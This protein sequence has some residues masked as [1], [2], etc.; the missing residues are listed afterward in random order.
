MTVEPISNCMQMQ[1]ALLTDTVALGDFR[2]AVSATRAKYAGINVAHEKII[3][4]S[5]SV[6]SLHVLLHAG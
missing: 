4:H 3:C 6:V 2:S 5:R 1:L